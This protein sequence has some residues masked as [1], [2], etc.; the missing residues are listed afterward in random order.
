[1]ATTYKL[2]ADKMGGNPASSYIGKNGD[3]FYDPESL[4]LRISNGITL[5]GILLESSVPALRVF[6]SNFITIT[7]TAAYNLSTTA[8]YNILYAAE[9]GLIA[10]LNMPASPVDGQITIFAVIQN[11]V[12]LAVGAG[13]VNPT[14]AGGHV[15]GSSFTY[16]YREFDDTWY[17]V[18]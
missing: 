6:T 13:T 15:L 10:T 9:A 18:G 16:S 8:S 17:R 4:Q 7:T 3:I 1:M 5:G 2:F 11:T 12:T 14:F